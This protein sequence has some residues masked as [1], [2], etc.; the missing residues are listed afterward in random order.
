M[1]GSVDVKMQAY[2]V[3]NDEMET[4]GKFVYISTNLS[5]L[6]L[7]WLYVNTVL[8]SAKEIKVPVKWESGLQVCGKEKVRIPT[9]TGCRIPIPR[10]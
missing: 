3:K 8:L 5:F 1:I 7:V 2:L 6:D 9:F 10:Q 4:R